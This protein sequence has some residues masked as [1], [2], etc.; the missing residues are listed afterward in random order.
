MFSDSDIM[1]SIFIT[2]SGPSMQ[3]AIALIGGNHQ[4]LELPDADAQVMPGVHWGRFEEALTPAF[5]VVQAWMQ[6]ASYQW[7]NRL[8][9][10][11]AEEVTGCLLGGHGAPARSEE[12]RVGQECVRT[13]RYRGSAYH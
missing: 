10:T 3:H 13:C 7:E 8:G 11:L 2:C 4:R 5:W 12:R 6:Q 1:Y 9:K